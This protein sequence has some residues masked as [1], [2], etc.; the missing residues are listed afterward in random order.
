MAVD[1]T[2]GSRGKK[3]GKLGYLDEKSVSKF[4]PKNNPYLKKE[5]A[6]KDGPVDTVATPKAAPKAAPEKQA[7]YSAPSQKSESAPVKAA[8]KQ[9]TKKADNKPKVNEKQQKAFYHNQ[10][11]HAEET[12]DTATVAKLNAKGVKARTGGDPERGN[13]AILGMV[14][15]MLPGGKALS[16]IGSMGV[17][18]AEA[19]AETGAGKA[20]TGAAGKALEG[21]KSFMQRMVPKAEERIPLPKAKMRQLASTGERKALPSMKNI[22]PKKSAPLV[23]STAGTAKRNAATEKIANTASKKVRAPIRRAKTKQQSAD[24]RLLSKAEK[25]AKKQAK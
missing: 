22:T 25:K 20:I 8:P 3:P 19:L 18:G 6:P 15:A 5:G 1:D 4:D 16:E 11:V 9:A 12:G 17:K 13:K 14:P 2:T 10:R 7:Y 24:D 21:A 23:K